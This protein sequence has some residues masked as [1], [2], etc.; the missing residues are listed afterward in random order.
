MTLTPDTD[1]VDRVA[2]LTPGNASHATRHQREKVVHAT[3]GSEN[4]FFNPDLPG[5]S[6]QERLQSAL[7]A[8]ALTPSPS[9]IKEYSER[10]A[11]AG[12]DQSA[13]DLLAKGSIPTSSE[14]RIQ[15]LLEF[16]HTLVTD[17]V[18]ADRD[19]LL[20]LKQAGLATPEIVALAQL[21]AFVSYQVRTVA[22]LRAM[23]ALE[24][25]T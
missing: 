17:P 22:G 2:G 21:I 8:A 25:R 9:L 6:L 12:S 13:I 24:Q 20:A 7:L 1:T 15:A 5:L 19:A 23:N 10:L 3:Q 16:T 4:L 18:K 11:A 14:A